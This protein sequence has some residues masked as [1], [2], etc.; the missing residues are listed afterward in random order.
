MTLYSGPQVSRNFIPLT[1]VVQNYAWGQRGE[2]SLIAQL[3]GDTSKPDAPY[4]ELWIGTHHKGPAFVSSRHVQQETLTELIKQH[5]QQVLGRYTIDTFGLDLPFLFKVLGI[6]APLSIQSHP[7][8][9]LAE[10]LHKQDSTNY[11]DINHKPEIAVAITELKM[12]YGLLSPEDT[13]KTLDA[14]FFELKALIGEQKITSDHSVREAFRSVLVAEN[15]QRAATVEAIIRRLKKEGG[16]RKFSPIEKHLLHVEAEYDSAD[17]G[18]AAGLL[19]NFVELQPGQ[20]LYTEPFVPHAY[21]KGEI[22]EVMATSDNVIRIGLTPKFKD[23]QTMLTHILPRVCTGYPSI[24]NPTK[25]GNIIRYITSASEFEIQ[26]ITQADNL[27]SRESPELLFCLEG[28]VTL[29]TEQER[30]TLN[31]GNAVLVPSTLRAYS[32][33]SVRPNA[34]LYRVVIPN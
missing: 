11:P 24:I 20:A 33:L 10:K 15:A 30:K 9:L 23:V 18:V 31:R 29:G 12:L 27:E 6:A 4:A 17:P 13:Q 25:E 3:V 7:D 28:T 32:V 16:C 19:M 2:E 14:V 5:P 34:K 1:G 26:Q 22:I 8:K 21:L